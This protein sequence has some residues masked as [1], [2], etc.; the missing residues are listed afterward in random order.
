MAMLPVVPV[1]LFVILGALIV[2]LVQEEMKI[3]ADASPG[4]TSMNMGYAPFAYPNYSE[5][6]ILRVPAAAEVFPAACF[7]VSSTIFTVALEVLQVY[8]QWGGH[9]I[10]PKTTSANAASASP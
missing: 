10:A 5:M 3:F 4:V 2:V 8:K 7:E 9:S 6:P 1:P